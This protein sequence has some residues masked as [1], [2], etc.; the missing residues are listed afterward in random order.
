MNYTYENG[1]QKLDNYRCSLIERLLGEEKETHVEES[2][3]QKFKLFSVPKENHYW[4]WLYDFVKEEAGKTVNDLF[5]CRLEKGCKSAWLV[6]EDVQ[7]FVLKTR[8]CIGGDVHL[9]SEQ[10]SSL[11]VTEA[12]RCLLVTGP[13]D[14]QITEVVD[15][16]TIVVIGTLKTV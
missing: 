12:G 16:E 11:P 5:I 14:L 2:D 15:G 3:K 7:Y 8:E 4:G 13:C 1:V 6:Q 9:Y 10:S